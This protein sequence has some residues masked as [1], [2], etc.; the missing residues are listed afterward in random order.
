MAA[1]DKVKSGIPEMDTALDNIRLGDNVVWRVSELSEFRLFMEPYIRQAIEDKRTIVYFRFASH[2]ALIDDIP[3]IKTISVPLTHRF[4]NFT[5]DIH[6]MIERE[7]RDVF[8]VFDCLS[9]LQ[10]AW[11]TDLMMGNFFRVTCPFLFKLDTVAF[12][13]IIRGKHSVHAID[14]IIDTTQLFFDV[15]KDDNDIYVRPEKVWNRDSDTM[16]LP[17]IFDKITGAFR[18]VLDGVNSSR[19]YQVLGKS[20]RPGEEQYI[21][22]WDRFF[23]RARILHEAGEEIEDYCSEMCNIMMTRD[24][25]IAKLAKNITDRAAVLLG[26]EKITEA[27]PEFWGVRTGINACGDQSDQVLDVLLQMEKRKPVTT[28]QMEKKTGKSEAELDELLSLAAKYGLIEYNWENLD[29]KNP[30]HEKRWCLPM[31]VPGSAEIMMMRPELADEHPEL[32]DF[33]ERMAFL[34]LVGVTEMVPPGGSGIGMHVIPVE[35][36]IPAESHSLPIEHI[37]HWLKKYEGELAI[38]VCSCRKQQRVRGEGSGDIEAEW[39]IGLGD[40]AKYLIETEKGRPISYEEA[41]EVLQKAEERGYVHQITNIDG[42]NKIFGL[43]NCAVGVCNAL[44]TSQL[45]NT[46]NM[47]ASAYCAES[48]PAKCVACGKCVETCPAGAVRLGQKLCTKDGPIQYPRHELPDDTKWGEEHWNKNYK[49]ENGSIQTWPTGTAPCK[50]AC[51]VHL[52]IQ[53]Y[54]KMAGDGRYADAL[55]LI[56]KDNPFPAVCGSICR[57]YCEDAC[58][59]G[60]VDEPLSIDEIKKF[61]AEQDMKAEHRYIP[62]MNSSIHDKFH[63]K[64]A[65]IGAGPAGM[66]C[67][68]F[69]AIEGYSPVVFDKEPAPGGML[70]NGIPS[71]RVDKDVVNSEIDVLREMGVEFRCGV[72]VGK[73]TTIQ[74]LRDQVQDLRADMRMQGV[75][76]FPNGYA[77]NAGPGPFNAQPLPFPGVIA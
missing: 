13:P 10:A 31:Y 22:S 66:S 37:S 45:F 48:D 67:A 2:E 30:K 70:V 41:M 15:Y 50:V 4:E 56:K 64:I 58:T 69:L 17:H 24:E 36:A 21:D 35:K 3:E 7:G 1:F 49:N 38:G 53:G 11:A 5:V 76:R 28:S 19:F 40:F 68:Y 77:F 65:I 18:P 12:F 14:K 26:K 47:S 16:F 72:E 61:V 34:P 29:G 60:T 74:Q 62:P 6:N 32:A 55:K 71:F 27:S 9:E 75:V 25:K 46:P 54:I 57:K 43:C 23:T 73:D 51:P 8:Y 59:R 39:C 63:Q 42:E 20:Q 44:R 33:F 52:S